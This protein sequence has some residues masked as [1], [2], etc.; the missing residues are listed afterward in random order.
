MTPDSEQILVNSVIEA[1]PW[2]WMCTKKKVHAPPQMVG[3]V[4][5]AGPSTR[6]QI[7]RHVKEKER[8]DR[9]LEI[10]RRRA[11]H[12]A[13]FD[14]G[15]QPQ[16][17]DVMVGGSSAR[18]LGPWSTA[19]QLADA[20]EAAKRKREEDI[21]ES[22]RKSEDLGS[23]YRSWAPKERATPPTVI[24]SLKSQSRAL[25]SALIEHVT[26]LC[27]VPDDVRA[28]LAEEVCAQR[29]MDERAFRLFTSDVGSCLSIPDCSG[30][31]EQVMQE[32]LIQAVHPGLTELTL[33]LCGR[34]FTESVAK[35]L[36]EE[37]VSFAGL[38]T[39]ILS[40]AYRITDSGV[41]EVLKRSTGLQTL[42]L[43]L[44]SRVEGRVIH[45][46]PELTPKLTSLDLSYC[47]GIPRE[48]LA[49]ALSKLH[50]LESL[51]LDG[52]VD[53]DDELLASDD[54]LHGIRNVRVLSL[55][56]CNLTDVGLQRISS[57]L[58]N[59]CTI[60]LDHCEVTNVG[61]MG[62]VDARPGLTSLSLKKCTMIDDTAVVHIARRCELQKLNLNGVGKGVTGASVEALVQWRGKTI[63]ELDL[64][65]CR[66][67]PEKAVG[68]L[69]DSCPRLKKLTLFGCNHIRKDLSFVVRNPHVSILGL[70]DVQCEDP[71]AAVRSRGRRR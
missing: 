27:G 42:G 35:A 56:N 23:A 29:N 19:Y 39:L 31:D 48:A 2:T 11:S 8:K 13:Q 1:R 3:M 58:E 4:D 9:A 43:P 34:G 63:T 33:G 46:L 22:R 15:P 53:V 52:I 71:M 64:S 59:L 32:G 37:G 54:V 41:I 12:F 30:I 44:C 26:T 28:T 49:L 69:A 47:C 38:S 66:H 67:V 57:S 40:G 24:P 45:C 65:W 16:G 20:K 5:E 6:A 50:Q 7:D 51:S 55:S 61:V 70:G 10:A 62:L 60:V 21:M 17:D 68:F 18:S 36:S 14:R 25:C